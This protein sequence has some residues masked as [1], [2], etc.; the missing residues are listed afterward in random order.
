MKRIYLLL[1]LVLGISSASFSKDEPVRIPENDSIV[2]IFGKK[3]QIVIHTQDK[4]ELSRLKNY[5]FNALLRQVIAVSEATQTKSGRKDTSFVVD[6]NRVV[7]KDNQVTVKDNNNETE[8]TFRVK[9]GGESEEVTIT[10]D[11][12]TIVTIRTRSKPREFSE[13]D[14]NKSERRNHHPKRTDNEFVFDLGLN[15]YLQ[16]GS[17]PDENNAPYGLRPLGSRYIAVGNEFRTRIGGRK[18]PL[19][20]K[21]G[22]EFSAN[23]FMFN[24]DVQI[25][26]GLEAVEFPEAMRN[27]RKSKLTVWYLSVPVMPMLNFGPRD[28]AK[29]RI[30]IGG[31]VGYRVH[32]YSKIVYFENGRRKEHERDNFYLN[33]FRYGLMGQVGIGDVNLFVKYDLNP[34]FVEGRGPELNTLSFGVRF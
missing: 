3:T 33:N 7:I 27:L 19:Y 6:G 32:S 18:S 26:R 5:D 20:L 15:N 31:F 16:N 21:Y 22:L 34:L 17:F 12:S 29:F 9:V 13:R 8:I 28:N 11:D 30:G 4:E 25:Q 2:I 1:A 23:N 10:E 14:K 24:R